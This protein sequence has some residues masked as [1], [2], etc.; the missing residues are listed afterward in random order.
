MRPESLIPRAIELSVP[1]MKP[2]GRT[3]SSRNAAAWDF[4]GSRAGNVDPTA[5][6]FSLIAYA[7][8]PASEPDPSPRGPARSQIV[9]SNADQPAATPR[10]LI[11]SAAPSASAAGGN[12]KAPRSLMP[13]ASQRTA[14][15][16]DGLPPKVHPTTWR[17][18]LMPV[19]NCEDVPPV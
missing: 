4:Q 6:P 14:C 9:A 11:A 8:P 3:P 16:P 12:G 17:A 2:S 7:S 10:P 15:W 18:P 13:L 1:S 5:T 19:A